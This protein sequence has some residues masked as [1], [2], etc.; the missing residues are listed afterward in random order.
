MKSHLCEMKSMEILILLR[1]VLISAVLIIA[2]VAGGTLG[3]LA[4][5]GC[6]EDSADLKAKKLTEDKDR[7]AYEQEQKKKQQLGLAPHPKQASPTN[8][9]ITVPGSSPTNKEITVPGSSPA[10]K[11]IAVPGSAFLL[12]CERPRHMLIWE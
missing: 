11:A 2:V 10:N 9:A 12:F 6:F 1:C 8:K 3:I 5:V 7:T 4:C